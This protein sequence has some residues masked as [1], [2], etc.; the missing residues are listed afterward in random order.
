MM[1][2][3]C[4]YNQVGRFRRPACCLNIPWRVKMDNLPE[5]GAGVKPPVFHNAHE[6]YRFVNSLWPSTIPKLDGPEAI[7]AAKR[8]WRVATGK[9]WKGKWVLTSGNRFN[10]YPDHRRGFPVNAPG[11]WHRLV[12]DISHAAHQR[13]NRR[14]KPHEGDQARLESKLIRYVV[15]HGWLEGKLKSKAKPK[16]KP[17]LYE[18]HQLRLERIDELI[19]GWETKQRRAETALRKLR[20]EKRRLSKTPPQFTLS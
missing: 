9:P 11:G 13:I 2:A 16:A 12:H 19:K 14:G 4:Y 6:H 3:I 20:I 18:K 15:E 5:T 17:T 1:L 7:S 10:A 8:L